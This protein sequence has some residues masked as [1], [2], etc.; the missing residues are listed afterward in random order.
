[1][2]SVVDAPVMT[3]TP[4]PSTSAVSWRARTV[5]SPSRKTPLAA[6]SSRV[7]TTVR[8]H[9]SWA[10]RY[11]SRQRVDDG[12]GPHLHPDRPLGL[13]DGTLGQLQVEQAD[14]ALARVGEVGEGGGLPVEGELDVVTERL[15][16]QGVLAGEVVVHGGAAGPG[17]GGD[18]G[19]P[20]LVVAPLRDEGPGR[21]EDPLAGAVG[22]SP[23]RLVRT[24]GPGWR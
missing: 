11:R 19:D 5:W 20:H 12:L 4:R 13:E 24:D 21:I 8:T 7:I 2:S 18:V 1:M 6:P 15:A 17:R 16:E 10:S 3:P 14:E 23:A 9:R 22:T